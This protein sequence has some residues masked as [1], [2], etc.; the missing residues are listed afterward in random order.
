MRGKTPR[1]RLAAALL[2][3][4]FVAALAGCGPGLSDWSYDLP[5]DYA[6]WRCNS[7]TINLGKKTSDCSMEERVGSY[8][9]MFCYDDRYVCV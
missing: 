9:S 2:I 1:R 6:I 8:I 3:G 5:N 4:L 7:R